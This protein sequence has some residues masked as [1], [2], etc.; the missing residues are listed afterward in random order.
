MTS[1]GRGWR[2]LMRF[3]AG[4][5]PAVEFGPVGGGHHGPEEWVSVASLA[6]YRRALVD[7]ATALRRARDGWGE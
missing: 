6:G 4:R 3:P 7:F 5:V 2:L 1:V